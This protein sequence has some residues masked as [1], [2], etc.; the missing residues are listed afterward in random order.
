[1]CPLLQKKNVHCCIFGFLCVC[2][3]E[4]VMSTFGSRG[5]AEGEEAEFRRQEEEGVEEEPRL[6]QIL[7][8]HEETPEGQV[9]PAQRAG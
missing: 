3:R 8:R 1:M 4:T 5:Q 6:H 7:C 9:P 2:E